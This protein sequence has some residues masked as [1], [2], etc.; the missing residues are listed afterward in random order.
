MKNNY[1]L[2]ILFVIGTIFLVYSNSSKAQSSNS[3][4]I[5]IDSRSIL[6]LKTAFKS[7]NE[8]LKRSA[9]YFAGK[10]KIHQTEDELIEQLEAEKS[11][12]N[13]KLIA[14]VLYKLRSN[15]SINVIKDM[16]LTDP[17]T[18]VKKYCYQLY[19]DLSG[20]VYSN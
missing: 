4:L 14:L 7:E 15:R 2:I 5:E 17:D 20:K 3:D 1:A 10:Y 13:K 9:I 12:R 11:E 6:N 18:N 16:A 8:G 19:Q